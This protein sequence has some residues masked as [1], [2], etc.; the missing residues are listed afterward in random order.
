MLFGRRGP[1]RILTALG[2]A[3]LACS[4]SG[5]ASPQPTDASIP[6]AAAADTPPV[7][8]PDVEGV[9]S[10]Q[11]V[12][13]C[14]TTDTACP[15]APPHS[16][17]LCEGALS[18]EYLDENQIDL[19]TYSCVGG[20]WHG[21]VECRALG[22]CAAPPLSETCKPHFEGTVDGASVE[23]GPQ[24]IGQPFRPFEAGEQ[25]EL[26]WGPQGSPM[27]E[28]RLRLN[29]ANEL[30]C[31]ALRSSLTLAGET[32]EL[33]NLRVR[34]RCGETLRVFAIVPFDVGCVEEMFDL[35]LNLSLDG[36]GTTSARLKFMGG[37]SCMNW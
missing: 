21:E 8:T 28:Y 32:V 1:S 11:P 14:A 5:G 37:G 26:I 4:S 20:H 2:A 22:G 27:L 19:W 25:V 15:E 33:A 34:V 12:V 10:R 24:E 23:V 16:G 36:V 18:C 9:D 29:G 35:D 7:D 3:A 30:E 13:V 31:V 17:Q 6:D